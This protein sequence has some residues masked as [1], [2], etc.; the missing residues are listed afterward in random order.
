MI[1]KINQGRKVLVNGEQ[2]LQFF[3]QFGINGLYKG[4][5][6]VIIQ[7]RSLRLLKPGG[8]LVST[9]MIQS[10]QEGSSRLATVFGIL[11][12]PL[13]SLTHPGKKAYFWDVTNA[14]GKDLAQY[15]KD[16][17][18]VF[19]LLNAGRIKPEIGEVMQLKDAP[20]AQ[21]MLLDYKVQGK[22]VLVSE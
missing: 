19:D 2:Q 6:A 18:A 21:Q 9:A 13:W 10:F 12:L 15:R 22:V 4:L 1:V 20:N 11:R 8:K 3:T 7:K 5:F 17:A 16:L 14:A